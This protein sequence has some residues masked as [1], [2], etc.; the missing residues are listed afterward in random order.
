MKHFDQV[1]LEPS[2]LAR[3]QRSQ[4]LMKRYLDVTEQP[5]T[6]VLPSVLEDM[7]RDGLCPRTCPACGAPVEAVFWTVGRIPPMPV[8][9][10]RCPRAL[11]DEGG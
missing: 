9:A 7:I 10:T 5:G 8:W 1:H 6:P 3:I 11:E 2:H 4:R